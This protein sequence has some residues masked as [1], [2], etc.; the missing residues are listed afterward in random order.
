IKKITNKQPI[1]VHNV[2]HFYF[3]HSPVDLRFEGNPQHIIFEYYGTKIREW[4]IDGF[5]DYQ[6]INMM[7]HMIMYSSA[8]ANAGKYGGIIPYNRCTYGD[9]ISEINVVGL[10]LCNDLKLKKQIKREKLTSKKELG[11][12]CEQFGY[13]IPYK[14]HKS[15][16]KEKKI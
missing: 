16:Y 9:L 14:N 7:Y 3:I 12:F 2:P 15:K 8:L 11:Q 13:E 1:S 10:E 4:N 6:I 5:L